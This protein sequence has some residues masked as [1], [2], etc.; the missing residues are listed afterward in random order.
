MENID[1][2]LHELRPQ[3]IEITIGGE[4]LVFRKFNGNDEAWVQETFGP[5]SESMLKGNLSMEQLCR[6]AFHQ[7]TTEGKQKYIDRDITF[8]DEDKGTETV[9]KMSG[10]RVFR[11][12]LAGPEDKMRLLRIML[13]NVGIS[14]PVMD[15][16]F[17]PEELKVLTDEHKAPDAKKKRPIGR[18]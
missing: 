5:D 1:L 18:K 2:G 3:D 6:I 13:T 15:K 17:S 16:I 12:T 11:A 8:Y 4:T 10:W 7:L 9:K 14:R